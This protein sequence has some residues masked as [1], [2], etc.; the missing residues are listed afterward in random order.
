MPSF[1]HLLQH[2]A[3]SRHVLV[4]HAGRYQSV[5]CHRRGAYLRGNHD[6]QQL[7]AG[8]H[9]ATLRIAAQ[10]RVVRDGVGRHLLS[11][12][13][14]EQRTSLVKP[15]EPDEPVG[16]RCE[17]DHVWRNPGGSHICHNGEPTIDLA[18]AHEALDERS[19]RL[20]AGC[21]PRSPCGLQ[22]IGGL[23]QLAATNEAVHE[24]AVSRLIWLHACNAHLQQRSL[25]SLQ[26]ALAA[27]CGKQH[28]VPAQRGVSVISVGRKCKATSRSSRTCGHLVSSHS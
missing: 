8:L 14:Q 28:I 5:V 18:S 22:R 25:E 24:R 16:E 4:A 3:C 2:L 27:C 7:K 6:A 20:H 19:V 13:L 23:L 26:V 10:Q 17:S 15:F 11:S 1:A 12:H 9:L 21:G